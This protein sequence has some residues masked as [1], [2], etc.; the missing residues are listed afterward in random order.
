M[1]QASGATDMNNEAEILRAVGALEGK[2]DGLS[3]RVGESNRSTVA[4]ITGLKSDVERMISAHDERLNK[5]SSRLRALERRQSWFLGGLTVLPFLG[6]A[7]AWF[8]RNWPLK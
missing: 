2:V 6:A 5:H 7:V 3:G 8:V 1:T 4:A